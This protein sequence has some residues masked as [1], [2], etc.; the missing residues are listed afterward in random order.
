MLAED[1][2][3]L[4]TDDDTGKHLTDPTSLDYALA[5]GLLVDLVQIGKVRIVEP[6]GRFRS[7]RVEVLDD[8]PTDDAIFDTALAKASKGNPRTPESLVPTLSKGLRAQLLA[9]LVE[10]GVLREEKGKVLGIFPTSRWPAGYSSHEAEIRQGLH[11]VLVLQRTPTEEEAALI[12]ILQAINQIPK[13]LADSSVEKR[14]L[15]RRA[16]E[17][18]E[19]EVA[20]KAVSSAVT[21]VTAAIVAVMAASA[22]AT[23][24]SSS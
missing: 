13:T 3:L 19:R 2:L 12:S 11:E 23:T 20:G 17:I 7:S 15:R 16:K 1:L 8:A 5:G 10:R 18:A 6:T 9:R 21:A 22:A 4:L 14:E 24:S